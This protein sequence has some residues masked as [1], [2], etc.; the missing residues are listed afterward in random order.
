MK[1]RQARAGVIKSKFE[2][3]KKILII[4]WKEIKLEDA[5]VTLRWNYR[6][7]KIF[8]LVCQ[9]QE[10]KDQKVKCDFS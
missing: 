3:E 6:L 2:D 10:G 9:N 5:L 7:L 8:Y 1:L 4:K